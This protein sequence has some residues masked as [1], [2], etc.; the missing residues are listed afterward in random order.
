MT[1]TIGL[2]L[3]TAFAA[4]YGLSFIGMAWPGG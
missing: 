3:F 2:Y 4:A 1:Q